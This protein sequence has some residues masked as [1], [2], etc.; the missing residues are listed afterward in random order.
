MA[1]VI[2]FMKE[3]EKGDESEKEKLTEVKDGGPDSPNPLRLPAIMQ[4]LPPA[5]ANV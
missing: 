4:Q 1:S 2:I 5:N 3:K